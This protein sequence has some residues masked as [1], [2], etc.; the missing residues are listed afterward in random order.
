MCL[1]F[2]P[3]SVMLSV[4][5]ERRSAVSFVPGHELSEEVLT[6]LASMATRAPSAFNFQNWRFIVVSTPEAKVRLKAVADGQ[7]KVADAAAIFIVCGTL[8]PHLTLADRLRPSVEAG[9]M[10]PVTA[11]RWV[12]Q[13]LA[14]YADDPVLQR[15]EAIRSA[16]MAAMTLMLAAEAFGLASC[17]IGGFD[18]EAL[19]REFA[20][21]SA[22][23]PVLLVAVGKSAPANPAQKPRYPVTDLLEIR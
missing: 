8:A 21:G 4:I 18:A 5:E 10:D 9:I 16:S 11:E 19:A 15:D 20:L 13:A 2:N 23:I 22:D 7:E 12:A 3:R 1:H 6:T 14:E 17:P